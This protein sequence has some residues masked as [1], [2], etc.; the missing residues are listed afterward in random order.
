MTEEQLDYLNTL[1]EANNF[2]KIVEIAK[3]H[4][5]IQTNTSFLPKLALAYFHTEEYKK[6]TELFEHICQNSNN[7]VDWFN[8]CTSAIMN[9]DTQKGLEALNTA[10]NLNKERETNGEGIPTPF[11]YLYATHALKDS[12]EFDLAFEQLN[13]LGEIYKVFSITDDTFLYMRGVPFFSEFVSLA[14]AVLPKQN[15]VDPKSWIASISSR[16]DIEGQK[17]LSKL[18]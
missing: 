11:M 4:E 8:L 7:P 6:S 15:L 1:F 18:F 2:E 16:L 17:T 9:N 14:E 3:Q 10:V 5:N 13:K 12:E